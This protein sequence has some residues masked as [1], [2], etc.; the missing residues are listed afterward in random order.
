MR[1]YKSRSS[2][3]F[4]TGQGGNRPDS[5]ACRT[6]SCPKWRPR[7]HHHRQGSRSSDSDALEGDGKRL[8]RGVCAQARG[9]QRLRYL[10]GVRGI[11]AA[12]RQDV[13]LPEA[14]VI[15]DLRAAAGSS[16]CPRPRARASL[17]PP[18][19]IS[20]WKQPAPHGRTFRAWAAGTPPSES[21]PAAA[22]GG[23]RGA[24]GAGG[25]PP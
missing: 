15:G 18:A 20:G 5:T 12:L 6:L 10:G 1:G 25:S 14:P 4:R 7:S 11:K 13:D 8:V 19:A 3:G 2:C 9:H 21:A 22:V 16:S 23:G 24:G 17:Q